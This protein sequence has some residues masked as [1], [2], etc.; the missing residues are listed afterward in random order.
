M[1]EGGMAQ[2]ASIAAA[3]LPPLHDLEPWR[4]AASAPPPLYS[5]AWDGADDNINQV[6]PF[7][8][9]ALACS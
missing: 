4:R 7:P 6:L 8:W 5:L 1:K 9:W 2:R 3:L